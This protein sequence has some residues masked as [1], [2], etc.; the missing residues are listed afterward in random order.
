MI[1]RQQGIGFLGILAILGLIGFVTLVVLKV[2]PLYIENASVNTVLD[3]LLT[4]DGIGS[5]GKRA[6]QRRID[7]QF[8]IDDV[9]TISSRDIV[10]VKPPGKKIW[11]VSAD[12]EGRVILFKNIG[13]FVEFKKT[14]EVPR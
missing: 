4:V 8:N 5:Q 1:K 2:S 13:V 7:N 6:M 9:K 12:Y 14:V 10:F 11:Q 3:Q